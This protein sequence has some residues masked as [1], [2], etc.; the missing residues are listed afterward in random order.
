MDDPDHCQLAAS[1]L[2]HLARAN[3]VELATGAEL[4]AMTTAAAAV[5]NR[6]SKAVNTHKE[7]EAGDMNLACTLMGQYGLGCM[8]QW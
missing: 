4:G 5:M 1:A 3:P 7:P 6:I 2:L 8:C